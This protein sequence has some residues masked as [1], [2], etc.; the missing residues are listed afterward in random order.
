GEV[1]AKS[2]IDFFNDLSNIQIIN[3]FKYLG[4][5]LELTQKSR[6]HETEK[7]IGLTFV[8]SGV[9]EKFDRNGL[10][11]SIEDNGGKI[12]SSIS[13]NTNY[14]IAGDNMGPSKQEKALS[15]G[16]PIITED[17]YLKMIE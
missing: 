3:K 10:K 4:L 2:I 6:E 8:V 16:V 7:L 5:Q 9:F 15:L 17:D 13:K 11:K 1:I 14:I 12:S